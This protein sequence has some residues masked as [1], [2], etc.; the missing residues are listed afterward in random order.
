MSEG[1]EALL[2]GVDVLLGPA[3]P[4]VAP[5]RTPPIDTPEGEVEGLFTGPFNVTGQ[6]AVAL[7]A[8]RTDDGLPFAVQLIGRTGA[9]AALLTACARIERLLTP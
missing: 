2:D 9:D 5:E 7:P 8:G 1:A 4:Y 3:A 6:P